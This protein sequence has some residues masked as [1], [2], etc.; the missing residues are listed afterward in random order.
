MKRVVILSAAFPSALEAKINRVFEVLSES[1][2]GGRRG[3]V[4]TVQYSVAPDGRYTALIEFEDWSDAYHLL[5][6]RDDL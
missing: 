3:I 4:D 5:S 6:S 2:D 1:I